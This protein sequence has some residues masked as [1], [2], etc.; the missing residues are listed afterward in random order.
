MADE[1][2]PVRVSPAMQ[3][4]KRKTA[5]DQQI[6]GFMAGNPLVREVMTEKLREELAE[7]R[8]ELENAT[9]EPLDRLRLLQGRITATK[10]LLSVVSGTT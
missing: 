7:L 8:E 10:A 9:D 1:K 2:Q 4:R 6:A 5:R 3:E